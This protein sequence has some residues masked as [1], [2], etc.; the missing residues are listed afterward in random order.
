MNSGVGGIVPLQTP[1]PVVLRHLAVLIP[2]TQRRSH[3][4]VGR[5]RAPLLSRCRLRST[6]SSSS[7]LGLDVLKG[8]IGTWYRWVP[9]VLSAQRR[10]HREAL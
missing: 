9:V 3:Q 10:W 6:V 7:V 8:F 2:V 5:L 4:L 1:S